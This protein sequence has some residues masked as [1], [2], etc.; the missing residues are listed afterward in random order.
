MIGQL[1]DVV[2]AGSKPVEKTDEKVV[3]IGT[4]RWIK[5]MDEHKR[6]QDRRHK[7]LA[8]M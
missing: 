5:M 1:M 7:A 3:C 4:L 2:M 8:G 6:R